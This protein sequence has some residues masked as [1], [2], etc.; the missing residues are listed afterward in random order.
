MGILDIQVITVEYLPGKLN[1]SADWEFRNVQD[2]SEWRLDHRNFKKMCQTFGILQIDLF[3]SRVSHP[4]SSDSLLGVM[5][6]K[7]LLPERRL[8]TEKFGKQSKLY[9][10]TIL[11]QF[12]T[13]CNPIPN[14]FLCKAAKMG[15]DFKEPMAE[16]CQKS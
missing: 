4:V 11:P 13:T 12:W 3:A 14:N 1:V 16:R 6:A 8:L 10:P 2:S 5:E 9:V 15:E 7:T